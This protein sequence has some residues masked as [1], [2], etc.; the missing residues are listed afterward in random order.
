VSTVFVSNDSRDALKSARRTLVYALIAG[1]ITAFI[2]C[3]A[4]WWGLVRGMYPSGVWKPAIFIAVEYALLILAAAVCATC[5]GNGPRPGIGDVEMHRNILQAISVAIWTAPLMILFLQG[6]VLSGV[7]VAGIVIAALTIADVGTRD[8]TEA[9][10]SFPLPDTRRFVRLLSLAILASGLLQA[11]ILADWIHKRALGLLLFALGAGLLAARLPAAEPQRPGPVSTL[12]VATRAALST[13]L[14]T[15]VIALGLLPLIMPL[16]GGERSIDAL[17]HVWLAGTKVSRVVHRGSV[18]VAA[19]PLEREGYIGVILTP[20]REKQKPVI[21]PPELSLA[22]RLE[23][24]LH[25]LTIR[26]TG[27]YWF[28]QYPFV[29]PPF[30]SIRADGDPATV[31]VRS[32]NYRPLL[33]EAVQSLDEPIDATEL[34]TI[35]LTMLDVDSHP[36]GIA[37]Q[38]VLTDTKLR[39]HPE[40][41]LGLQ[42]L[43]VNPAVLN[44]GNSHSETLS[45]VLPKQSRCKKFDQIR[46]IFWLD[47]SHDRQAAAV[48]VQGFVL[49]PKGA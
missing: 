3:P 41:S 21:V 49:V 8:R 13:L 14:A 44:A 4:R 33:M 36:S 35:Q 24:S 46:L 40:Q 7:L 18:R 16:G 31:R 11:A 42:T 1:S 22:R 17:L 19:P 10:I 38:L 39:N 6:S 34:S 43:D 12:R 25:P 48:A 20:L 28:F 26:F 45:F 15:A 2:V 29:R 5:A 9:G 32:S 47:P 23:G 30:D 27:S 37:I